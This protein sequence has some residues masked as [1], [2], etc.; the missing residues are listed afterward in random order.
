MRG[1][2]VASFGTTAAD[3]LAETIGAVE[4]QAAALWP[5]APVYR[6]FTSPTVR[7]RLREKGLPVEDVPATLERMAADGVDEAVVRNTFVIRGIEY[8]RLEEDCRRMAGAFRS[9]DLSPP[10]LDGP[11]DIAAVARLL[12]ERHRDLAPGDALA[13]MGHGTGH[14]GD[15]AY[16]A[17]DCAF[18]DMGRDDVL[19]STIEGGSGIDGLRRRLAALGPRRVVL[20]PLLMTVGDHAKNDMAGGAENSWK[21]LLAADGYQ[22]TCVME[23]LSQLPGIRERVLMR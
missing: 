9:L 12:L 15:F 7:R 11:R 16:G 6:A 3:T 19:V 10:L 22:V 14:R 13:L 17:L 23:G 8:H 20:R 2:L 5:G 18:R 21:N 4:Q 1:V